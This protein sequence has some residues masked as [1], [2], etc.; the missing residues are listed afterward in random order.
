MAFPQPRFEIGQTVYAVEAEDEPVFAECPDCKGSKVWLAT[1]PVGEKF[2]FPCPRCTGH[3]A[4]KLRHNKAVP[5]VR[6]LTIGS[7]RIDTE[8]TED[9]VSYMCVETGIGSGTLWRESR[10]AANEDEIAA[11]GRA[12]CAQRETWRATELERVERNAGWGPAGMKQRLESA[13]RYQSWQ[14]AEI[15]RANSEKWAIGYQYERLVNAIAELDHYGGVEGLD[16]PTLDRVIGQLAE[17]APQLRDARDSVMHD[18]EQAR[19]VAA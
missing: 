11:M 6:K 18:R 9:S 5:R 15:S 13:L 8:N 2:D 19:K 4:W 1:S 7:V 17:D 3:D 14:T 16:T 10:L 12:A